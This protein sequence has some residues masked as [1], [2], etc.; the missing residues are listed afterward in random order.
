MF[1]AKD[2]NIRRLVC[3]I[4]QLTDDSNKLQQI[5][6]ITASMKFPH[7]ML[8]DTVRDMQLEIQRQLSDRQSNDSQLLNR[9]ELN[10]SSP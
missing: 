4:E 1:P 10:I 7:Q 8:K 2:E 9:L 3:E 5:T 6:D